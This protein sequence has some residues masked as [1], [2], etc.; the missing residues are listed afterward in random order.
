MQLDLGLVRAAPSAPPPLPV[1]SGSF[2]RWRR[3]RE[4]TQSSV[5]NLYDF[6][7]LMMPACTRSSAGH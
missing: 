3:R 5:F 2:S 4:S 7:L 6:Q 1:M